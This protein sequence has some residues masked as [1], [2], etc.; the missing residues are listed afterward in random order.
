M[1]DRVLPENTTFCTAA[2]NRKSSDTGRLVFL[3]CY[4]DYLCDNSEKK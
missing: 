1:N 2:R 4:G 3:S